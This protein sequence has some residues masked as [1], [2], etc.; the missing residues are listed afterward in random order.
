MGKSTRLT[1]YTEGGAR[2]NP[3]PAAA[4]VYIVDETSQP[5]YGIVGPRVLTE[6]DTTVRKFCSSD[7]PARLTLQVDGLEKTLSERTR[8][9]E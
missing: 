9:R 8:N 4:G 7:F 1:I 3:G 6:R 5:V 2:G